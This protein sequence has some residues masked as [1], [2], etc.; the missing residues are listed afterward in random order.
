LS[1]IPEEL[2]RA[3]EARAQGLCEYCRIP[4]RGQVA[5]FPI[6][7]I[8][9]R[10]RGGKTELA[11]LAFA[12]P[13]CNAHKWAHVDGEDATNGATSELFNPREH[14]WNE[15]FAWSETEL[16]IVEGRTGVGRATV[17]RLQM[18][19]PEIVAIR[20]LLAEMGLMDASALRPS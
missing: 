14:S 1:Q 11:N 15:H 7:H 8:V 13:R 19:D 4:S 2:R 12:C 6:D 20:R 3:A 16:L 10:S 5:W 9:P 17:A 18:N